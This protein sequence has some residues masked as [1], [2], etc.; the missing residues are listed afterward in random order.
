MTRRRNDPEQQL[1]RAVVELLGLYYP[2]GRSPVICFHVPMGGA[3]SKAEAAILKGLGARAGI[4]D[5]ILLWGGGCAGI[6]LKVKGRPLSKAQREV[7]E[8]F[9]AA[10]IPWFLV[11]SVNE[12][13]AA[14][15]FLA[16]GGMPPPNRPGG[17][18]FRG[19]R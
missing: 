14:L 13:E 9:R 1:Q 5:L 15:G 8:E 6:E 4:P 19:S 18:R 2:S 17:P 16:G 12:M 10:R 3:R 11:Q 7:R